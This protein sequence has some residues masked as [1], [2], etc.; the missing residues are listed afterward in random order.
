MLATGQ[1]IGR[2]DYALAGHPQTNFARAVYDLTSGFGKV[3]VWSTLAWQDIKQRYRGS[4]LGPLWLTLTIVIMVGS[5]GFLYAKLFH[6]DV[7]TY[8]PFLAV[9]MVFWQMIQSIITDSCTCF[10]QAA[11]IVQQVRMPFSIHVYRMICRNLIVL[12]HTVVVV[13]IVLIIFRTHIGW[14]IILL[15]PALALLSLNAVF[16]GIVL[17]M[18]SA[19]YRDV[20]PIVQNLVQVLFFVTPV[21]WTPEQLGR[22]AAVSQFNPLFAAIDIL[23]SPIIG[24]HFVPYVS[25]LVMTGVTIVVGAVALPMFSR[26]RARIPYWV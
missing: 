22:W 9:G 13:P 4:V 20:P 2:A 19:R 8:L 23:R 24:P 6:M 7:K 12:A 1:D 17:G 5:M 10:V 3:W 14:Q 16:L 18:I 11:A 15:L 21:F 26:Y 25:W